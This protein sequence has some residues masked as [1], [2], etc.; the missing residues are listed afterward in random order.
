VS[1]TAL[2]RDKE[3]D[4]SAVPDETEL[5]LSAIRGRRA[6]MGDARRYRGGHSAASLNRAPC[7]FGCKR[8]SRP[9]PLTWVHAQFECTHAPLVE[10]KS[11]WREALLYW[12]FAL[13]PLG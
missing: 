1:Q 8:G 11:R 13:V 2:R 3:V 12:V 10:R 9:A 7:P 6:C 5:A 4:Y